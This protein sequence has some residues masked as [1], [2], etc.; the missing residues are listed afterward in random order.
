MGVILAIFIG[1]G[2]GS[3][4]RYGVSKLV[5]EFWSGSFPM[6]TFV[7][8]LL[9]CILMGVVVGFFYNKI[10]SAEMRALILIGFCGGF[11]TFSTFSKET[12]TLMQTGNYIIALL[13]VV[14]S[15][16]VC[17]F[18]LWMFTNRSV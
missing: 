9:S 10:T 3:I 11:S 7:A 2:L 16:V 4:S 12:L 18:V 13:N 8:N 14:V 5:E 17:M 15:I 6:G 1:G